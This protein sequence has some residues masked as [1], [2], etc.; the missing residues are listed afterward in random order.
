MLPLQIIVSILVSRLTKIKHLKT[1]ALK[2]F[3]FVFLLLL[4]SYNVISLIAR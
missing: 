3:S 1:I 4:L 2:M